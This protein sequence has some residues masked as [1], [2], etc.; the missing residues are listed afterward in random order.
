[1]TDLIRAGL[2][3]TLKGVQGEGRTL[4]GHFAVFNRFTEINSWFEGR[5]LERIA[6][7]A[8]LRTMVQDRGQMRILLNHGRDPALGSKPIAAIATLREDDFG[9][10][11]EAPLFDSVDALVVE[12]LRA[13]QYGA[14]FRFQVLREEI[15]QEPD[16]SDYN[17]TALPERTIKEAKVA[18]FGPVTWGAYSEA[19]AGL[20][21]LTDWYHGLETRHA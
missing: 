21:S 11:Y 19:T 2:P 17:P 8:F 14:S 13:G 5:F 20:R 3:C 9:A 6:P 18:E 10:Y 4:T 12:G 7:G 16:A 1:V 15:V